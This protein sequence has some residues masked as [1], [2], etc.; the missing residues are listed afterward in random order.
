MI[1]GG[2]NKPIRRT[3]GL[4]RNQRAPKKGSARIKNVTAPIAKM[5]HKT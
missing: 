3:T 1:A 4:P 5:A 2:K